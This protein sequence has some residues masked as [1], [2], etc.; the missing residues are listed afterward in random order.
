M[1]R[2]LQS[3]EKHEVNHSASPSSI[4]ISQQESPGSGAEPGGAF[5]CIG[6]AG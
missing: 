3:L 6:Y 2:G 5:Q 4:I 1:L